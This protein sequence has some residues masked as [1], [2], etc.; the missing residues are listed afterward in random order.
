MGPVVAVV[1][2]A[3]AAVR[4]VG[5]RLVASGLVGLD[6]AVLADHGVSKWTMNPAIAICAP[7][8]AAA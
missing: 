5:R 4:V 1:D 8:S 3:P 6:D 7:I 2:C